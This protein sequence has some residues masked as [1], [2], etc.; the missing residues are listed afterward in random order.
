LIVQSSQFS[1]QLRDPRKTSSEKI[2]NVTSTTSW[3]DLASALKASQTISQEI[4]LDALLS[5]LMQIIAENAG[6][7][8]AGLILNNSGSWEIVGWSDRDICDL[9]VNLF[10]QSNTLPHSIINTVK[11]TKKTLLINHVSENNTFSADPYLSENQPLSLVCTPIQNQ[12]KLIGLLYLENNLT[13]DA[14]T[15]NRIE[16]LNLLTAQAAISI[17][18]ARLYGQLEDYSRNLE[19]KVEQRTQELQANNLQLQQTLKQ[20][21]RTQAQLIQ[22]EK[23]SSLGQMVA[24]MAHEINNP[25]TFISGNI[26]H[27]REYVRDV[28]ELVEIYQHNSPEE[29]I[30][31]KLE[32]IEW[33]YLRDDLHKLF[34]SMQHGSDRIRKIILGLRNFSRLQEAELKQVDIHEGL[35]NTL[36]IV[37]HRLK[38]HQPEIAIVKNYAQVPRIQCYANQLN[39]VFLNILSNAIDALTNSSAGQSPEIRLTTKLINRQTVRISIADNGPGISEEIRQKVFDPFFTTKPVGKGTGLG[40]SM[41]YQIITEQ[42]QGNLQCISQPG[43]GTEF[44]IEIPV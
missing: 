18:N 29:V 31:E 14:F 8:R 6:A 43:E 42:H 13:T 24:G 21:Q 2:G 22:T 39:Q 27:A 16:V 23:M 1:G 35:E 36:L 28:F 3:I 9:S 5:K 40:L 17:E 32:E 37:Q 19:A 10:D 11:R 26:D 25:I 30:Q 7:D 38:S 12:G 41:S 34:D 20:L 15:P 33:E 44:I 4:S